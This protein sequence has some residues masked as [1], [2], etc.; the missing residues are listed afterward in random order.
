[1]EEKEDKI[2]VK[3]A[4]EDVETF[5]SLLNNN[6]NNNSINSSKLHSHWR[7]KVSLNLNTPLQVHNLRQC[8]STAGPLPGTG[9]WHQLYRAAR[10]SPGIDN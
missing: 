7:I 6:I 9:P 2:I 8:F 1:M 3:W 5:Y 10:G 4:Q